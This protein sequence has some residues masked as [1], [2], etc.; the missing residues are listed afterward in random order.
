MHYGIARLGLGCNQFVSLTYEQYDATKTA[1]ENLVTVLSIE[2]KLNLVLE[3]YTE[4]E[5]EILEL[6]TRYCLFHAR[7]WSALMED[8]QTINRRLA[9][10]MS[11]CRLYIDQVKH[12]VAK[13]YDSDSDQQQRLIDLFSSEYDGAL[14]YRVLEALRNFVQ[15]RSLPVHKLEYSSS[16]DKRQDITLTKHTCIPT[17]SVKHIEDD[18]GFKPKVLKELKKEGE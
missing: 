10:L 4:F 12:D 5:L 16:L 8:T 6:T 15:H 2:E 1:K 14:G 17:L 9:H 7:D 3:S 11:V 18:G 13:V